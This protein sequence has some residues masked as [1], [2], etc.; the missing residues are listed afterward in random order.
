MNNS[1][2]IDFCP[3]ECGWKKIDNPSYREG[4]YEWQGF[5]M[6]KLPG[7]EV[8][9][10]PVY[11]MWWTKPEGWNMETYNGPLSKSLLRQ[12]MFACIAL[13]KQIYA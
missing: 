5:K 2:Y 8:T 7:E 10:I 13:S 11:R 12:I 3:T 4:Y 9:D 6:M 1:E